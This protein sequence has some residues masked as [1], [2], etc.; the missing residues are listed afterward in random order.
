M[1]FSQKELKVIHHALVI[2]A[3]QLEKQP[4]NNGLSTIASRG[5]LRGSTPIHGY[6]LLPDKHHV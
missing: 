3:Y 4:E 6:V 2:A 5:L 1:E